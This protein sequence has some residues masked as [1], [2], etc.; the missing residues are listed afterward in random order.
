VLSVAN[1][2]TQR[3]KRGEKMADALAYEKADELGNPIKRLTAPSGKA[4]GKA[5]ATAHPS[6]K[7]GK[8]RQVKSLHADNPDMAVD[9]P[10]IVVSSDE[11]DDSYV[12]T[13]CDSDGTADSCWPGEVAEAD[14]GDALLSNAE[15]RFSFFSF[16]C[17][18]TS[19]DCRPVASE[20]SP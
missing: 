3:S 6:R 18:D 8:A 4:S 11:D 19:L 13:E 10:V 5:S 17:S 7:V 1:G 15:V 2:R 12:T 9:K 14:V 16:Y 20:D